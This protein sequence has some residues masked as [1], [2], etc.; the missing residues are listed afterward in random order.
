MNILSGADAVDAFQKA[1]TEARNVEISDWTPGE[2]QT[3]TKFIA[4]QSAFAERFSQRAPTAWDDLLFLQPL[5][6]K[7]LRH[8]LQEAKEGDNRAT[9]ASLEAA[10]AL[11]DGIHRWMGKYG[12]STS[13]VHALAFTT[14]CAVALSTFFSDDPPSTLLHN[15]FPTVVIDGDTIKLGQSSFT[16][17]PWST[18]MV[19]ADLG[20]QEWDSL[21]ESRAMF[22]KRLIDA[23]TRELDDQL[24]RVDQPALAED[25]KVKLHWIDVTID[26]YAGHMSTKATAAK[27]GMSRPGVDK[28]VEAVRVVLGFKKLPQDWGATSPKRWRLHAT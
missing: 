25:I 16:A 12:I 1:F 9:L 26:R 21:S 15:T 5:A 27:H 28:A 14:I 10:E 6:G 8:R 18:V 7:L 4:H 11:H 22:R 24:S 3:Q 17:T 13:W 20:A 2:F 19:C 23:F